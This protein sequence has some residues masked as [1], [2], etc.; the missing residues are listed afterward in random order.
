M[1]SGSRSWRSGRATSPGIHCPCEALYEIDVEFAEDTVTRPDVI[2]VCGAL[3]GERIVRAPALIAEVISPKTASRDERT[4]FQLYREEGVG[5]YLLLYPRQTKA[6][7][8][9]LVDGEYRKIGDFQRET[10]TIEL[11]DC[12]IDLDIGKL[13]SR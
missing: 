13:W 2:V 11:P 4:K 3:E 9:R 8:Y 5:Y 1:V 7:V 12:I 10:C 6:K